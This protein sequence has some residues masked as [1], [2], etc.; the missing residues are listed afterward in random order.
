[1]AAIDVREMTPRAANSGSPPG[2]ISA[3]GYF[4]QRSVPEQIVQGF[5]GQRGNQ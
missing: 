5:L 2:L 4:A 1:M 3:A